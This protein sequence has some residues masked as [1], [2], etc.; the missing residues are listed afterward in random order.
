M[1]YAVKFMGYLG[2][3]ITWFT[4]LTPTQQK[5]IIGLAAAAAAIGP[6][7]MVLGMLATGIGAIA[8]VIGLIS[9]PVLIVIGVIAALIA[10]GALLYAAWQTDWGGIREKTSTVM[11]FIQN[12]I[13]DAMD[14]ITNL[15]TGKMGILSTIWEGA[16]TNIQTFI[17]GILNML[18]WT[19]KAWQDLTK[20][21]FY[22]FG[23]DLRQICETAWNTIVDIFRNTGTTLWN[24]TKQIIAGV[25]NFFKSTDWG[26]VGMGIINGIISGL[27]SGASALYAEIKRI[28]NA[29]VQVAKGFLKIH[30]PSGLMRDVI[31]VPMAQ[32]VIAGW[33]G[34]LTPTALQPALA[35]AISMPSVSVPAVSGGGASGSASNNDLMLQLQDMLSE[36]NSRLRTLPDDMARANNTIMVKMK[37]RA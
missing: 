36:F 2:Q 4:Q 24:V 12:L 26:A 1:P 14:F 7:L 16:W 17:Q 9:V 21:N 11:L 23:D 8:G 28:V 35:S 15:T 5:W 29:T 27:E 31:G 18:S 25:I 33:A 22:A 20:G 34:T 30:S 6:L 10:I 3:L 37:E 13:S 19:I 32:G